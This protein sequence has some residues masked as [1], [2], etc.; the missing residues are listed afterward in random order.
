MKSGLPFK[1]HQCSVSTKLDRKARSTAPYVYSGYIS[2][3]DDER[4]GCVSGVAGPLP[5]TSPNAG[6]TTS[7]CG[8]D[9]FRLA[10]AFVRLAC[11]YRTNLLRI[12]TVQRVGQIVSYTTIEWKCSST[13]VHAKSDLAAASSWPE[14]VHSSD[15][16]LTVNPCCEARLFSPVCVG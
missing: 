10:H 11:L 3:W 16:T 4:C 7:T 13:S 12:A 1:I 8:Y 6:F 2:L 14:R 9:H 5:R 15:D